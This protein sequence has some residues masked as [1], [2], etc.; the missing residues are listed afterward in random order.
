MSWKR[1]KE[2]GRKPDENRKKKKEKSGQL[3]VTECNTKI[4]D[5]AERNSRRGPRNKRRRKSRRPEKKVGRSQGG[6][7]QKGSFLEPYGQNIVGEPQKKEF[8]ARRVQAR[9]KMQRSEKALCQ[10]ECWEE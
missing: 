7:L 8:M 9:K 4:R 1:E 6:N 3:N 5:G 10:D 2:S